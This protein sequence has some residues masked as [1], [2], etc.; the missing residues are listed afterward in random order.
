[1]RTANTTHYYYQYATAQGTISLIPEANGRYKVMYQGEALGSYGNALLASEDV[2][3]GHTFSSSNGVDFAE[4][5]IPEL[6]DWEK[7]QFA[8]VRRLRP[9]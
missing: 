6:A 1:M 8:I 7:K 2:R 5:N 4:L 9:G 3:G